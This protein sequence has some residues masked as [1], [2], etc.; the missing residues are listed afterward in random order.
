[1]KAVVG[2]VLAGIMATVPVGT[3]LA[4]TAS[5]QTAAGVF[6]I[7][8][9]GNDGQCR[10]L[11]AGKVVRSFEC[12]SASTPKIIAHYSFGIGKFADVVVIQEQPMGNACNGGSLHILGVE[13]SGE[14]N[15]TAPIYF[16]GGQ[17]PVVEKKGAKILITFPGGPSNS[18]SGNAR[19]VMWEY[20]EGTLVRTK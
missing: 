19:T 7:K 3:V 8:P 10:A 1:M 12:K 20:A 18:G 13:K 15:I 9:K 11:F 5:Y 4:Q 2:V 17:D 14:H 6:E 16:C